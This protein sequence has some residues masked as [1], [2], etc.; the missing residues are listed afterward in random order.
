MVRPP[1]HHPYCSPMPG[2]GGG[3]RWD[4]W[5]AARATRTSLKT[6]PLGHLA[7]LAE[8]QTICKWPPS[9]M[10]GFQRHPGEEEGLSRVRGWWLENG[11]GESHSLPRVLLPFHCYR[12]W[13]SSWDPMNHPQ[14][15]YLPSN[16]YVP[17]DREM[18]VSKTQS[19][20]SW[21]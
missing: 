4:S 15:K 9:Q 18:T 21:S 5:Q 10:V 2:F 12:G 8:A 1:H 17:G 13:F 19:L 3:E 14:D 6:H 11:S 7:R 20:P 16:Y